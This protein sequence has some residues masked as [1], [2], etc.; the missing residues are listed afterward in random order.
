MENQNNFIEGEKVEARN[1]YKTIGEIK[2]KSNK[3]DFSFGKQVLV[4]FISG[5]VGSS[6]VIGSIA[7]V[8]EV[9]N[10]FN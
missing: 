6:V 5:I 4:P 10:L 2:T 3:S 1:T 9:K 8:P 7:F